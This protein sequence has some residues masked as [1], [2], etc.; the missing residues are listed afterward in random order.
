M[1]VFINSYK[2][3]RT[4]E[5]NKGCGLQLVG[6]TLYVALDLARGLATASFDV[7]LPAVTKVGGVQLADTVVGKACALTDCARAGFVV[8]HPEGQFELA[9]FACIAVVS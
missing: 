1:V 4:E 8:D 3:P 5:R 9:A 6:G 2:K 7:R